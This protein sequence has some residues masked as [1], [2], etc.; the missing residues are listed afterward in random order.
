MTGLMHF[1]AC[2]VD[3]CLFICKVRDFPAA[4]YFI[5]KDANG[6]R[7]LIPVDEKEVE[8]VSVKWGDNAEGID[9]LKDA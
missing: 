1:F 8:E 6:G 5:A 4:D 2:V 9:R 3:V 7:Y